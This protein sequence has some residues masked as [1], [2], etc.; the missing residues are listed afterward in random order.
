MMKKACIIIVAIFTLAF[1]VPVTIFAA[2]SY[3]Q[4]C[5]SS[6]ENYININQPAGSTLSQTFTPTKDR[7]TRISAYLKG[8]GTGNFYFELYKGDNFISSTPASAEPN[9]AIYISQ[10]FVGDFSVAPG[11]STYKI[12]PRLSEGNDSLYWNFQIDCYDGGIAYKGSSYLNNN[13]RWDFG[14][15]TFGHDYSGTEDDTP[16]GADIPDDESEISA[17]GEINSSVSDSS[18]DSDSEATISSDTEGDVDDQDIA[19]DSPTSLSGELD[20][21]TENASDQA[22]LIIIIS[23]ISAIILLCLFY[24][25]TNKKWPFVKKA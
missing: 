5:I 22:T 2:D 11:D 13:I 17:T 8:T 24:L 20:N 23:T 21:S 6:S 18:V 14:F 10:Y 15:A 12:V 4:R 19:E 3:D 9:G 16:P 1:S 25:Y 7:I